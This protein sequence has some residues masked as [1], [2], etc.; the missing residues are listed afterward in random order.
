MLPFSSVDDI[1]F[2]LNDPQV[3]TTDLRQ[4]NIPKPSN[5]S[6]DHYE[7]FK[8]KGLHFIHLNVRSLFNKVSELKIIAKHSNA[9]V[10]CITE[11]WL[12]DS[13]TDASVSIDGYSL[14]RRDRLSHGGGVCAYIREDIAFNPRNDLASEDQEDLWFEILL[15]KSKPLY[16]GAIYR[17]DKN[18]N[19][20][21]SLDLSLSKLRDDC[22]FLVLGDFNICILKNKTNY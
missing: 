18:K 1:N 22:D 11:S 8:K 3:D 16:V 7:C 17:T 15:P 14:L 13:H 6:D 12:N 2:L 19:C 10:I 21:N 9:A 4:Y 20:F 5:L